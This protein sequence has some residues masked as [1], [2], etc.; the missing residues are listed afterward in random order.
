MPIEQDE[1]DRGNDDDDSRDPG[2]RPCG[3]PFDN[4]GSIIVHIH[5]S[6]SIV[7][8]LGTSKPQDDERTV[9]GR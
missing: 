5:T 3:I 1:Q 4:Y 9:K 2:N 6:P 8:R 7:P